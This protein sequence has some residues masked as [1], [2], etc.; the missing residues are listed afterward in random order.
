MVL[1]QRVYAKD[2]IAIKNFNLIK[3]LVHHITFISA[4]VTC[5]LPTFKLSSDVQL[6]TVQI[7]YTK[8]YLL[9]IVCCIITT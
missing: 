2:L 1:T 4:I 3:K 5:P 6:H 7:S 8:S 9:E